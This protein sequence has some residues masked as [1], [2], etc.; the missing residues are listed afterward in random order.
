MRHVL[1]GLARRGRPAAA[2]P[3]RRVHTGGRPA[4]PPRPPPLSPASGPSSP[5][6]RCRPDTVPPAPGSSSDSSSSE[7]GPTRPARRVPRACHRRSLRS[8]TGQV[9]TPP[10]VRGSRSP[11]RRCRSAAV[12]RWCWT[13]SCTSWRGTP[14][15]PTAPSPSSATTRGPTPGPRC[16][17]RTAGN[18]P[19]SSPPTA[20][21]CPCT[22]PMR[23]GPRSTTSSTRD[24][25]PGRSCPAIRWPPAPAGARPG[26]G[27]D[28]CS[29]R[30]TAGPKANRR[31]TGCASRPWTKA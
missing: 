26:S 23:R 8:G 9:T 13:T 25:G 12:I 18:G 24:A 16:R 14:T 1:V 10:P 22:R 20:P 17:R 28:C 11:M 7:A 21:S 3:G 27:I 4:V 2:G 30:P 15:G 6:A 31:K 19:I 5:S 29:P